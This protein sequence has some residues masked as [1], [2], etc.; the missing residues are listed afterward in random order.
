MVD[1][2]ITVDGIDEAPVFTMGKVS[3]E[4][5]EDETDLAVYTFAA[6]RPRARYQVTYTLSGA[7]AGKFTIPNGA[8]TFAAMP[9][10]EM[11]CGCGRGQPLR[12]DGEGGLRPAR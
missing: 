9:D 3:H 12:G 8:L 5:E 7:D 4:H 1:M 6:Y 10:F 2:T 11:A